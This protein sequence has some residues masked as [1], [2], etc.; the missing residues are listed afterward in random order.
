MNGVC[1]DTRNS[2]TGWYLLYNGL[3]IS[4][5]GVSNTKGETYGK[6][7]RCIEHAGVWRATLNGLTTYTPYIQSG[8]YQVKLE[9]VTHTII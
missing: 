8:C 7:S 4:I 2:K 3:I 6:G 5:L 1:S 9:N